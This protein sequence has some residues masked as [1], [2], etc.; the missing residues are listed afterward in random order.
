MGHTLGPWT[1]G[2]FYYPLSGAYG[3][4]EI[5]RTGEMAVLATVCLPAEDRSGHQEG[6]A[7]ATLIAAAPDLLKACRHAASLY[8]HLSLGTLEAAVKYGP[9]YEPPSDEDCLQV[10]GLLGDAI[11]KAEHAE[12][13]QAAERENNGPHDPRARP[14]SR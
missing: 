8:D 14:V 9:N 2:G 12:V 4:C 13:V 3:S 10:R 5:T 6:R 7:N 1:K 11:A